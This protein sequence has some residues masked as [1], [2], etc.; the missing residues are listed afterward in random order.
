MTISIS[1]R[2]YEVGPRKRK[3]IDFLKSIKDHI[4][5]WRVR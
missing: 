1:N 2:M 4:I 5:K 3:K